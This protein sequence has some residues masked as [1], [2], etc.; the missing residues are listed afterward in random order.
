MELLQ[1][2]CCKKLWNVT[3]SQSSRITHGCC[4]FSLLLPPHKGCGLAEPSPGNLRCFPEPPGTLSSCSLSGNDRSVFPGS[5]PASLE[6]GSA[7]QSPHH[8]LEISISCQAQGTEALTWNDS[9]VPWRGSDGD[10]DVHSGGFVQRGLNHPRHILLVVSILRLLR[11]L[12]QVSAGQGVHRDTA[13]ATATATG[14]QLTLV[15][16]RK[17][18][19]LFSMARERFREHIPGTAP[20]AGSVSSMEIFCRTTSDSKIWGLFVQDL[21]SQSPIPALGGDCGTGH[22]WGH[23][24]DA[25]KPAR[26]GPCMEQCHEPLPR[27][28]AG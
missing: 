21:P 27:A 20:H 9:G 24:N 5:L 28:F 11:H 4:C 6:G 10:R 7:Q 23:F 26:C 16:P 25:P 22:P 15:L 19:D 12:L 8:S 2:W 18:Q 13:R 3:G 17:K 1:V 14:L